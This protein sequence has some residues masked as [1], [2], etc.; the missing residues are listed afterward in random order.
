MRRW[1]CFGLAVCTACGRIGFAPT[2]DSGDDDGGDPPLGEFGAVR[3]IAELSFLDP[4]SSPTLTEDELEMHF[5]SD[6]SGVARLHVATR[7]VRTDAWSS[8]ALIAPFNIDA[9]DFNPALA[10]DG[11]AAWW[12]AGPSS[13]AVSVYTSSRPT[14]S[15]AWGVAE[16]VNEISDATADDDAPGEPAVG[17][18]H[19]IVT[20]GF[21]GNSIVRDLGEWVRA[22]AS[23]AWSLLRTLDE[24][25]TTDAETAGCMTATGLRLYLAASRPGNAGM[26]DLYVTERASLT[27]PFGALIPLVSLN[28]T[29]D[30]NSP[31]VSADGR[32]IYFASDRS[33]SLRLYEASIP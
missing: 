26:R 28:T 8:V 17:G 31:W 6:S 2:G 32:R 16:R 5:R 20:N 22:D 18:T 21:F 12:S 30:D 19:M 27:T 4:V 3:E 14:R 23:S 33:G 24:L 29:G 1:L 9:Y 10:P 7:A 11:L 25:N 13:G 15:T